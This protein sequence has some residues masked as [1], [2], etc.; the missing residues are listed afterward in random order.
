VDRSFVATFRALASVATGAI[1]RTFGSIPVAATRLPLA[2]F[3][4]AFVTEALPEG[5]NDLEA[6]VALLRGL[7]A[8]FTVHVRTDLDPATRTAAGGLGLVWAGTLPG[9]A[10]EPRRAPD[11]PAALAIRRAID[12]AGLADHRAVAAAGFAMPPDLV[13]RLLSPA[14][15]ALPDM[16]VYVG[17]ADGVP[18]ASSLAA[19]TGEVLGIYNVATIADARGRGYGTAM[20]WAAIA[21]AAPGVEV[22]VLQASELGR[23]IYERMGFRTVVEYD[24]LESAVTGPGPEPAS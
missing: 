6:A 15:L 4:A 22:V 21:D 12:E 18:V 16:R 10:M 13:E 8:P 1:F 3:N 23:P 24:E 20:T 9:M 5:A 17:V 11:P 2:F 19:R 14:L 7:G